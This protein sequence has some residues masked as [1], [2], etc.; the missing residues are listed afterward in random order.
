MIA[1]DILSPY[2]NVTIY[3]KE[4]GIGQKFLVAGKGGFNLTNSLTGI[5][6]AT[7]YSPQEFMQDA[8]LAFDSQSLREWFSDLGIET[9]VGTSGRV[10]PVKGIM[11]AEVLN[12]IKE[13]LLS[14][15][16]KIKQGYEFV[17]FDDERNAIINYRG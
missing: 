12:K 10:F 8:I 16:V 15:N 9:F 17:G 14:Q 13:K 5:E 11:P 1:A 4:K 7:Q 2:H 3:E 6:L